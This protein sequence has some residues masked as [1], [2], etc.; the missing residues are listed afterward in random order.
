VQAFLAAAREGDFRALLAVLDPNVV[1]RADAAAVKLGAAPE[2]RG[3][4]AL[5]KVFTGRA[6]GAREALV[7]GEAG[8]AWVVRGKPLV[9]FVFTFAGDRVGAIDLIG[10]PAAIGEIDLQI[11]ER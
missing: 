1:V 2:V 3:A 8:L 10:D 11:V 5:S 6:K 4:E 9:V 7:D